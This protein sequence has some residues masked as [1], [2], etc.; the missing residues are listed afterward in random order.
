MGISVI[1]ERISSSIAAGCLRPFPAVSTFKPLEKLSDL[2]H[3][4]EEMFPGIVLDVRGDSPADYKW[5]CMKFTPQRRRSS[6]PLPAPA[7]LVPM[8]RPGYR[9]GLFLSIQAVWEWYQ[10]KGH[11][12]P[13]L[14]DQGLSSDSLQTFLEPLLQTAG[15]YWPLGCGLED[16]GCLCPIE[17]MEGFNLMLP[18]YSYEDDCAGMVEAF[19][20]GPVSLASHLSYLYESKPDGADSI[21]LPVPDDKLIAEV[22]WSGL[23]K[24]FARFQGRKSV[25]L[26]SLENFW[27]T[28]FGEVV[29]NFPEHASVEYAIISGNGGQ[30]NEVWIHK[31]ADI[32]FCFAY[33]EAY[34]KLMGDFPD[35]SCF[36]YNEG[37]AAETFIHEMCEAWRKDN[38][39]RPVKW[40]SPKTK[41][42][43][44]MMRRGEL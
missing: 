23:T 8:P 1:T 13:E 25:D 2:L 21:E 30:E 18:F 37:G 27:E 3:S 41:T 39:K 24:H 26:V 40:V 32:D 15:N 14:L 28:Y 43:M 6:R 16:I 11:A 9:P 36:D 10:E 34:Y 12:T 38:R 35:P 44:Q 22:G 33:A 7:R 20:S 4:F 29:A 5:P 42:L 19:I 31:K 17:E